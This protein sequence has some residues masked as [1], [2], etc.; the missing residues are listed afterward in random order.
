MHAGPEGKYAHSHCIV[1]EHFLLTDICL[2]LFVGRDSVG[3]IATRYGLDGQGIESWWGPWG[4]P[5]LLYN[6]YRV[7]LPGGEE[8]ETAGAWC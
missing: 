1:T 4:P 6:G 7:S 2:I 8:G 3:G 5:S